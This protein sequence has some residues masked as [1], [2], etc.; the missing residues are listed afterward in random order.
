MW[1][2]ACRAE[3]QALPRADPSSNPDSPLAVG[4]LHLLPG[5][6]PPVGLAGPQAPRVQPAL[7]LAHRRRSADGPFSRRHLHPHLYLQTAHKHS[8]CVLMRQ[9]GRKRGDGC[10][11]KKSPQT[12][13]VLS[14][15]IVVSDVCAPC[16][17]RQDCHPGN[18]VAEP[19]PRADVT[20][21]KSPRG[22]CPVG[23]CSSWGRSG[24]AE[25]GGP[26]QQQLG[27]G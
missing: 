16:L 10:F 19:E 17:A 27:E 5:L 15:A 1:A 3:T 6:I 11:L 26:S 20:T 2:R 7:S 14:C 9:R 8:A 21:S 25:A 22:T 24:G 13:A 23:M 12:K 4:G 18:G